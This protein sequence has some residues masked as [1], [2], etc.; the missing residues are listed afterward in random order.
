MIYRHRVHRGPLEFPTTDQLAAALY[1]GDWPACSAFRVAG[2]P[3]LLL[4]CD[5]GVRGSGRY[6]VLRRIADPP[7]P[8]PPTWWEVDA[9]DLAG[10]DVGRLRYHLR[11][12][13]AGIFDSMR[14]RPS[15]APPSF[16]ATTSTCPLCR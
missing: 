12:I 8:D 13:A 1:D 9:L 14:A 3:D 11:R 16:H 10:L 7:A 4:A 2:Y 15:W 6:T 5:D